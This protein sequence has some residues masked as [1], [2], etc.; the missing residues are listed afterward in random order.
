MSGT[1]GTAG[2]SVTGTV[3]IHLDR[4][5]VAD[6]TADLAVSSRQGQVSLHTNGAST[7]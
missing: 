1:T 7:N 2:S 6:E 4:V 3:T 5:P